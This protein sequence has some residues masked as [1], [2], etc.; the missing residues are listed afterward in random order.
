MAI[1]K[2]AAGACVVLLAAAGVDSILPAPAPSP[3]NP[4]VQAAG[5]HAPAVDM[6]Q[7]QRVFN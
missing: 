6:R 5:A 4:V 3:S 1:L 7:F 2:Y